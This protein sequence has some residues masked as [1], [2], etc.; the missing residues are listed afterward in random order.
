VI[1]KA[2]KEGPERGGELTGMGE[3]MIEAID[4]RFSGTVD[5][6][7]AV[8]VPPED[9]R[10]HLNSR[11]DFHAPQELEALFEDADRMLREWT[12]HA[13]HPMHFGLFRPNVDE[14]SVIADALAALYDPNLATWDF[15][16]AANE[17]E[18]H[19]LAAIAA[20]FGLQPGSSASHFTSGGQEANHTAVVVALTKHFPTVATRGLRSLS[21]Q[22][23][24]Y[25]S[26]EAHH[27]LDKVAGST[28]LGRDA[29]RWVPAGR[30]LRMDVEALRERIYRDRVGGFEPFMVVSTAGTTNAGVVDPLEEIGDVATENGLWH[31]VDAAWGGAAALSD[32]L[33]PA[34][35]G[36]ESADSIT[37][38]AHKW[39]SV[40]VGA[41]MFFCR[42]P[43][44]VSAAFATDTHYVPE[45]TAGR[46]YPFMTSM[47]WSR[48]F[49]GF[50][51]FLMLAGRGLPEV[52]RRIEHQT[53][54][55]NY[56]RASL[57]ERGWIIQND[58]PLPVVCFTHDDLQGSREAKDA[59]SRNLRKQGE[60]WISTTVL[61]GRDPALR[62]CV[63]NS[64]TGRE[65]VDR[66][67]T[68]LE[69]ERV[70]L[71]LRKQR[72][73]RAQD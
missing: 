68:L 20:R 42:H 5:L 51:L 67:V 47:Q 45:R 27:S 41:G 72:I 44:A 35:S 36:I 29:V 8:S 37:C 50:K 57:R 26:E 43:E 22:P 15:A 61:R 7:V 33:R 62:A 60:A 64:S 17:I 28:G 53:E 9:I 21:A 58:T 14:A 30:D 40:P 31:H 6:P 69:R 48:R 2:Q 23:V 12:E 66:L 38:D 70:A 11:Y 55:G 49:T 3:Q 46:V 25:V 32:R 1:I 4:R 56:L 65:H 16:P 39:I 73:G 63:T 52:A 54:M 71:H 34:L 13:S 18:R 19:T 10:D 59:I 24:F